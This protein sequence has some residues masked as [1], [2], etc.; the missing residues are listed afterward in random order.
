MATPAGPYYPTNELVAVAWLSQ[1]VPGL[2]AAM[3]ATTLPKDATAWADAG[4]LQVQALPG[5]APDIDIPVR[6]PV[7]QLDGWANTPGSAK[8]PWN[9]ANRLLEL[10]RDATESPDAL[11]GRPVILPPDYLGVRVQ[12]A[13]LIS[14]PRRVPDDPAGYARFTADLAIDWV[15]A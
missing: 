1:R 5:G 12:A 9:L 15:R 14:E 2:T 10:V 11:Y 7:F 3:V 13:Y 8:P 4:F 6:H